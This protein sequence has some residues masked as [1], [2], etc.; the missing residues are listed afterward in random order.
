[1]NINT[2]LVLRI[3]RDNEIKKKFSPFHRFMDPHQFSRIF[4]SHLLISLEHF[5]LGLIIFDSSFRKEA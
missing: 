3:V 5:I 4:G 2:I 1:M